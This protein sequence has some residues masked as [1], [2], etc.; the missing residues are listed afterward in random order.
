MM[1]LYLEPARDVFLSEKYGVYTIYMSSELHIQIHKLVIK[2]AYKCFIF[3]G[4]KLIELYMDTTLS[5]TN[6]TRWTS[7]EAHSYV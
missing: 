4:R 1:A 7:E 2:D 6:T 5:L 3:S